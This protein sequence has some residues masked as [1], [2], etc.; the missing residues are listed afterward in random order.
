MNH[1]LTRRALDIFEQAL[2]IDEAG[3][4]L[5]LA[6]ICAGDAALG[7]EVR[8]LLAADAIAERA[9]PTGDLQPRDGPIPEHIGRYRI[10]ERL[11]QGG[12]GDVFAGERDDGLFDHAVA[13]KRVRPTLFAET[14]K[15]LFDRER[16]ALATLSHRH[17]AQLFDGGV[18]ETG[19][20]YLIMELV[21]GVCIDEFVRQH[22][23]SPQKIAAMMIAVCD[24][25]QHAH[26]KLI[27]HADLKPANILVNEAGDPKVVDFGVA[28]LIGEGGEGGIYPHTRGYASPQ[29]AAGA[30]PTPADDVYALGAILCVLLTGEPP[31]SGNALLTPSRVT[32]RSA[33]FT[34]RSANWLRSRAREMRGDLDAII[35]RACAENAEDRYPAAHALSADLQAWLEFRPIASRSEDTFYVFRKFVRRRRWRVIGGATFSI[36]LITALIVTVLLYTQA[37][38]QRRQAEARFDEVHSLARYLLYD[39]YDRLEQSPQTLAMR[40]DVARVAQG[41]LDVLA[42]APSAPPDVL[43]EAA[44]GLVRIADLQAGRSRANLGEL[45]QA[46]ANLE[47]ASAIAARLPEHPQRD[48]STFA[49]RAGIAIRQASLAMNS[50]QDLPR[51]SRL[52]DQAARDIAKLSDDG[53][54]RSMLTLQFEVESAVLAN[55]KGVYAEGVQHAQRA[56]NVAGALPIN[57][58][59]ARDAHYLLARAWDAYAEATYYGTGE[60]ASVPAYSKL[61]S[62][63]SSYASSH[64]DDMMGVRIAIEAHWALGTT[65]LGIERLRDGLR[66]LDDANRLLPRLL[67]FQPDDE[68]ARRTQQIVLGARA[69]ALA[70][71]GRFAEGVAIL[72]ERLASAEQAASTPDAVAADKRSLAVTKTML[73]DLYADSG[74]A[75][76]ACTLYDEADAIFSGLEAQGLLSQLDRDS[77]QRMAREQKDKYCR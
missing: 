17:I 45:I 74:R 60:A 21:R 34:D 57:A 18:D 52:L 53:K 32:E 76:P 8:R 55:W 26:Q 44:E 33:A 50:N 24:A 28:R 56:I 46:L 6:T 54:L 20:P 29:R 27:V 37:D 66:E 58:A 64:P 5:W 63:A 4:D 39:V 11:G 23:L 9:L 31:E 35:A 59:D 70:M 47:K 48:G 36:A 77:A 15:S 25:V 73:A 65:L 7:S 75:G 14:A 72:K 3:R 30:A 19:A 62:I 69:Q 13:I 42:A 49:L 22:D 68:G 12:M 10:V 71:N 67:R 16:R 43:R 38:F 51:A 40:R 1:P 41:Y 2:G 61:V